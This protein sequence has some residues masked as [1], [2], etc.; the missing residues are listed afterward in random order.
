MVSV[1]PS[2]PGWCTRVTQQRTP[3]RSAAA[4]KPGQR[5]SWR[6][7][8][9]LTVVPE[10]SASRQGASPV[11]CC[12]SN[13]SSRSGWLAARAVSSPERHSAQL[14]PEQAGTCRDTST[15]S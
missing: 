6:V 1:M 14:A 3:R 2:G 15:A 4:P 5:G 11:P 9:Q 10:A 8:G 7:S 12:S 13:S